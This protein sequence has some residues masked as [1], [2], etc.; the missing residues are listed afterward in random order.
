MLEFSVFVS[1]TGAHEMALDVITPEQCRAAR[2]FVGMSQPDLA[3]RVS[4]SL[5]TIANFENGRSV[6]YP[7]NM[8]DI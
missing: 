2:A 3:E 5:S 4:V 7:K 6:P 1:P 8:R